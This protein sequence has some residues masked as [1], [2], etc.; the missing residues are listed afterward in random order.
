MGFEDY[1]QDFLFKIMTDISNET[2]KI[3][4]FI[5]EYLQSYSI[6]SSAIAAGFPKTEAMTIGINLLSNPEV[7]AKLKAREETFSQ[8]ANNNKITKERLLNAMMFQYNKANKFGKTKEAIEILERMAK[9]NGIDP[10]TVKVEPVVIN[11][12]NLDESKI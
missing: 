12:S 7:Q 10:D 9:W 2:I 1:P 4:K 6:E 8:I 5:D 3:N 11:I